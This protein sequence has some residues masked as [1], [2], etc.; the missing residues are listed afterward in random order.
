VKHA[1]AG[2]LDALGDLLNRAEVFHF[3]GCV[4]DIKHQAIL[5][6]CYAATTRG[7]DE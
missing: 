4:K 7:G 6:T 1:G 5:K 3:L 2:A